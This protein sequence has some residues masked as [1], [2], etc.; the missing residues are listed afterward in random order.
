MKES[1]TIK[2]YS[3]RL[4]GIVNRVKLLGTSFTYSRI[5]EKILVTVLETYKASITTLKNTKDLSK[6]TLAELLNALQVQEK[7]R[8]MRQDHVIEGVLQAKYPDSNKKKFFR[9][10]NQASSS[11]KTTT[12]Q[13]HNK[14]KFLKR[15]FSPCQHCNKMGHPPFKCWKRPDARCSKYNQLGHEAI[16]CRT[17]P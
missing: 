14:E 15:N 6:I 17:K 5:V 10:K 3:D 2:E 1:E 4:L 12:S 8:L 7:R 16:I 9:K 11:S 13:F